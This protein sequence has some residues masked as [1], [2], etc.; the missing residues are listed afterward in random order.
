MAMFNYGIGGQEEKSD[1]SGAMKDLDQNRT[2]FVQKLTNEEPL[3]P[4]A[5]YDLKTIDEV[6]QHYKPNVDVEFEN[7]EGGLVKENLRFNNLGEFQGKSLQSQSPFLQDLSVQQEQYQRI[8]KQ[9]KTN[10][11]MKTVMENPDSKAAFI[12]ALQSLIQELD[13]AK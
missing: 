8:V 5:V 9:L 10:K 2:L 13:E 11:V 3:T 1:A 12:N 6:F 7:G 4:Q